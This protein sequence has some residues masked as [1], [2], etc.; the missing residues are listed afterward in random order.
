MEPVWTSSAVRL[1][2]QAVLHSRRLADGR[3]P[4]SAADRKQVIAGDRDSQQAE[5]QAAPLSRHA[6]PRTPAGAGGA[7]VGR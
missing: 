5:A 7:V 2:R 1:P 3:R 4:H 6:G